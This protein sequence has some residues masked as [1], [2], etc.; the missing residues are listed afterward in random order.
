M[1]QHRSKSHQRRHT[2]A[3]TPAA[4][5]IRQHYYL[6]QYVI[7][8]PGR[9][10]RPSSFARPR[11]DAKT[12]AASC[13]FC[14]NAEPALLQLPAAGD[15]QV[16]VVANAFPALSLDN[17]HA[18][19]TQEVVIDTPLHGQDFSGLSL[20]HMAE[21]LRAYAQRL[22]ALKAVEG[23]RY[24]LV[25]K[26]NGQAAGASVAHAHSQIIALPLLPPQIASESDALNHY[27]DT[28]GSC[29]ICDL[30]SWELGQGAR[31][32]AANDHM[33]AITPYAPVRAF[34]VW[35]IP[36]RHTGSLCDLS[37]NE[38]S[39]LVALLKPVTAR[40]DA[41]G[42]SY[43]F[44]FQE[45]VAN[46]DHHLMLRVEPRANS[47]AGAEYGTGVIINPVAPEAAAQWYA[48]ER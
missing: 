11:P 6:N 28:H 47:W 3:N 43:N 15:W 14:H 17:P 9:N 1:A 44:F 40:L 37:S 7:I 25:F 13:H 46:Q 10:R 2:A 23:V 39:G 33:V 30:L 34:E 36:R 31:V 42:I 18:F 48:E 27:W 21:V 41:A 19:G 22:T 4:G 16:K 12:G 32:V 20:N 5:E 24:V 38:L 26:N 35:F 29:A 45:S 8:A